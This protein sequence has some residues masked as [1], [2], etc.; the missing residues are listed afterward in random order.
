MVLLEHRAHSRQHNNS[1]D[2]TRILVAEHIDLDI[3]AQGY[4]R[5]AYI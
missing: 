1:P 3:M 2:I 5:D 4:A